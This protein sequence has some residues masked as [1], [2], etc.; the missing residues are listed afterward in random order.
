MET[1]NDS[2]WTGLILASMVVIVLAFLKQ[3]WLPVIYFTLI[4]LVHVSAY[5]VYGAFSQTVFGDFL[6]ATGLNET[7]L[8]DLFLAVPIA[9]FVLVWF[10]AI[11]FVIKK[12]WQAI[13]NK[14][15]WGASL[16]LTIIALFS[17]NPLSFHFAIACIFIL[18][19]HIK[20]EDEFFQS[21]SVDTPLI[22]EPSELELQ[23]FWEQLNEQIN[24]KAEPHAENRFLR[25]NILCDKKAYSQAK[26]D[27]EEV[28]TLLEGSPKID[29][30]NKLLLEKSFA[31]LAENYL[32]EQ[33]NSLAKPLLIKAMQYSE[34]PFKYSE[35]LRNSDIDRAVFLPDGT[36][37]F[38]W[39]ILLSLI[40]GC[41]LS[42]F[43]NDINN[44]GLIAPQSQWPVI[45]Q[46]KWDFVVKYKYPKTTH[47]WEGSSEYL[48]DMI[49]HRK[50]EGLEKDATFPS[51]GIHIGGGKLSGT[52]SFIEKDGDYYW[53]ENTKECN[54]SINP[55]FEDDCKICWFDKGLC[56]N[57]TEDVYGN[58]TNDAEILLKIV[59]FNHNSIVMEGKHIG[60]DVTYEH[61][62]RRSK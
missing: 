31:K 61:I 54:M 59:K 16:T 43:T 56:A 52:Y 27:F 47:S 20:S 62:Y 24:C 11:K 57:F 51:S 18:Y 55:D 46:G 49:F 5:N 30:H 38:L 37:P 42:F 22:F 17:R 58:I 29:A 45:L 60:T 48:P 25:A 39:Q 1:I 10:N 34:D 44:Q 15:L 7:D 36:S 26:E 35:K 53:Q 33:K 41:L 32:H 6:F 9:L 50:M 2:N 28:I 19:L 8:S 13:P 12:G 14:L 3:R 21:V 23:G 40:L 4:E